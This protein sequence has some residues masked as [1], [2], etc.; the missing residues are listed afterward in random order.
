MVNSCCWNQPSSYTRGLLVS[1]KVN[2]NKEI[3]PLCLFLTN[4]TS[5]FF[6][7]KVSTFVSRL[8]ILY[9]DSLY[10]LLTLSNSLSSSVNYSSL[11]RNQKKHIHNE[12]NIH[13]VILIL[14]Y[15]ISPIFHD[16]D[17]L[18]QALAKAV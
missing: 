9:C 6:T 3:S 18:F 11:A 14:F 5:L 17:Y 12:S 8:D 4:K 2:N 1:L 10:F 16:L 13:H 15:Y 7:C